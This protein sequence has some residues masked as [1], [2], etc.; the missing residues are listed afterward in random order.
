MLLLSQSQWNQVALLQQQQQPGSGLLNGDSRLGSLIPNID[1][2]QLIT[3]PSDGD[4]PA[5]AA[6]AAAAFGS[7][8]GL[9]MLVEDRAICAIPGPTAA[10]APPAAGPGV[11]LG[12]MEDDDEMDEDDS[13]YINLLDGSAP[14][15]LY[16]VTLPRAEAAVPLEAASKPGG[17]GPKR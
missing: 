5:T 7:A 9:D 8:V 17:E 15:G 3:G 12:M 4:T 13:D 6:A 10:P 2:S 11:G 14:D 1:P 16:Q